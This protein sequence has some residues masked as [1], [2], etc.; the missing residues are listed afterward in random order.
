M[1]IRSQ[2]EA[3]NCILISRKDQ[4][5][6]NGIVHMIDSPLDPTLL[7]P[8]DVVQAVEEV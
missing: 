5:A 7:M 8:M 3:V 1:F 2:M 4:E 6:S